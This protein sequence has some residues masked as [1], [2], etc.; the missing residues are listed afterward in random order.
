M[1]VK[2]VAVT[3]FGAMGTPIAHRLLG[4]GWQFTAGNRSR[5]RVAAS[6]VRVGGPQE[7]VKRCLSLLAR[8][9]SPMC[10]GGPGTGVF[11]E[12]LALG[13]ALGRYGRLCTKSWARCRWAEQATRRRRAI[14]ADGY[15]AR[16]ALAPARKDADLV[17]DVVSDVGRGLG[18]T[19]AGRDW[20]VDAEHAGRAG[21]DYSAVPA[22]DLYAATKGPQR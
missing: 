4:N 14:G 17:A 18:P 9:D 2:R 10:V 5:Q 3:G 12:F 7:L 20:P 16:F 21:Q 8:L 1:N 6:R 22:H 13:G 15:P 11:S 19:A